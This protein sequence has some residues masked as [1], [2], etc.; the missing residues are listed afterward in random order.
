MTN[1]RILTASALKVIY[2]QGHGVSQE[3]IRMFLQYQRVIIL[4]FMMLCRYPISFCT[5]NAPQSQLTVIDDEVTSDNS[6]HTLCSPNT[7]WNAFI[8]R[9]ETLQFPRYIVHLQGI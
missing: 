1:C 7:L 9:P 4:S 8:W 2:E 6:S 5:A 3:S